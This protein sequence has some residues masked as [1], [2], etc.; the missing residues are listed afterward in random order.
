MTVAE[1]MRLPP[2]DIF[3][4]SDGTDFAAPGV[5]LKIEQRIWLSVY[6]SKSPPAKPLALKVDIRGRCPA[7]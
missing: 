6:C 2:N 7:R 1:M 4:I 5:M 3:E